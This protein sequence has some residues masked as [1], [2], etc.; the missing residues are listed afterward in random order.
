MPSTK[1]Y[2][3]KLHSLKNTEKMTRT[4]KLVSMSK[5][6]KAQEMQRRAKV[7]ADKLT[8]MIHRLAA[9][10]DS[11]NHPLLIPHAEARRAEILLITS[12][13]G[14]CGGY[15]NN[16]SRR[17]QGWV[18]SE[19]GR[20]KV[21]MSFCGKRGWMNLKNI[22]PVKKY[23]EGMTANPDFRN[24]RTIA[25]DLISDFIGNKIDE[26]YLAYNTYQ[27]PLKQTPIFEKIL[28][29]ERK[30]LIGGGKEIPQEYLFEPGKDELLEFLIPKYL[31]FRLYFALLENSAG[32]HGARMTAM[33]S[34]S[35][36]ADDMI[37]KYTLLRNRARQA[38]ITKE[39]IEI[40]SGA[41]AL[42]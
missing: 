33:D 28:P 34:A 5:L 27:S 1:E 4:M 6:Y 38:A 41:E 23:Y 35:K 21:E 7:Y 32:E 14:L 25:D 39:L 24:A 22:F 30:T 10:L 42:K 11:P 13:K 37:S 17:V 31:Y 12:D 9:S 2:D 19:S 3:I 20:E 16:L 40:V 18:R 26:V 29:I 15:N 8:G 36:N